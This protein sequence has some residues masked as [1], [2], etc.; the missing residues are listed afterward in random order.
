MSRNNANSREGDTNRDHDQRDVA[1][2]AASSSLTRGAS[3]NRPWAVDQIAETDGHQSFDPSRYV[4]RNV[5]GRTQ[6]V[7]GVTFVEDTDDLVQFTPQVQDQ[8]RRNSSIL[9]QHK[10]T[11]ASSYLLARR[12]VQSSETRP[13]GASS[14]ISSSGIPLASTASRPSHVTSSKALPKPPDSAASGDGGESSYQRYLAQRRRQLSAPEASDP[15]LRRQQPSLSSASTSNWNQNNS[16]SSFDHANNSLELL[17]SLSD[18]NLEGQNSR[19]LGFTAPSSSQQLTSKSQSVPQ[20]QKVYAGH[21]SDSSAMMHYSEDNLRKRLAEM[22]QPR[23]ESS[24][25]GKNIPKHVPSNVGHRRNSSNSAKMAMEVGGSNDKSDAA[26]DMRSRR[27]ARELEQRSGRNLMDDVGYGSRNNNSSNFGSSNDRPSPDNVVGPNIGSRLT[28]ISSSSQTNIDVEKYL[29][30]REKKDATSNNSL[31][32]SLT[33]NQLFRESHNEDV[34][35][36][37]QSTNVKYRARTE[38]ENNNRN[39]LKGES[40]PLPASSKFK[41]SSSMSTDFSSTDLDDDLD[42]APRA[43]RSRIAK[44]RS[45][46]SDDLTIL[47]EQ[48]QSVSSK[49]A[50]SIS[51]ASR[52]TG[53]MLGKNNLALQ[54][55]LQQTV[56]PESRPSPT[57]NQYLASRNVRIASE[58]HTPQVGTSF[59]GNAIYGQEDKALLVSD[60]SGESDEEESVIDL[61]D[62]SSVGSD[63]SNDA[64]A[65]QTDWSV[66]ICIVSAVDFP[67]NVVPN[68]P[69]SPLLKVGLVPFPR[70]DSGEA[71]CRKISS[72]VER[73]GLSSINKSRLRCS[74]TKILSKRDNG[75]VEYHEEMRWDRVKNPQK[76]ALVLELCSRSVMTPANIK[77]SPPPQFRQNIA[78]TL[79]STGRGSGSPVPGASSRRQQTSQNADT[80]SS[81][82]GSLFRRPN[83]RKA[84]SAEMEEANAAAAVAKLLV[85]GGADRLGSKGNASTTSQQSNEID[86]KLRPRKK[87]SFQKSKMTNDLRLGSTVVPLTCLAL[88][89]AMTDQGESARIEQWFELKQSHTTSDAS[90]PTSPSRASSLATGR[91]PSV[92]LEITFTSSERLN[93]SEDE[94]DDDEDASPTKELSASF[95][96]RASQKIRK[97]LKQETSATI[98]VPAKELVEPSLEPGIIDYAFIVGARD[99]G[100]QKDDDGAKGWVNSTPEFCILEQFPPN[101]EFHAK[102]GRKAIL[103]NKVEWFCFPDGCRLWRGLTPPNYDEL[104]LKRFSA[105]SPSQIATSFASFDACLGCTTCFSWFVMATNS[106]DYGS[107]MVKTYGAIIRFYVPAPTGIDPKQDDYAQTLMMSHSGHKPD[108]T[109][110]I[111]NV[112]IGVGDEK[113]RLWVNYYYCTEF[114]YCF[115]TQNFVFPLFRY[116]LESALHQ[117]YQSLVPWR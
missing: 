61:T 108:A 20:E 111:S 104:R 55:R 72:T 35:R 110:T 100:D 3:H 89:K 76:T 91:N 70:E 31:L 56:S 14:A 94:M 78:L 52:Q 2:M 21:Q 65:T 59:T 85:Q 60:S 41:P 49:I 98:E 5:T 117:I 18:L 73:S 80:P 17:G 66:R 71:S 27:L 67:G 43:F 37:L 102:N 1:K 16:R 82:L 114:N 53:E 23:S 86:V 54:G 101:D 90:S 63:A 57:V 77:E 116:L 75:S 30:M 22:T 36:Y 15:G 113:K 106:E 7:D 79:Q 64:D 13:S 45:K 81:G 74:S 25:V 109:K 4:N 12:A 107:E 87:K 58:S 29:Q 51:N 62:V 28:H 33:D 105:S 112:G 69:F 92:L 84:D 115:K 93:D 68:L 26:R 88:N 19:R 97:Q 47:T 10:E 48:P 32:M 40:Q 34:E 95:S 99:I 96:K 39:S 50:S 9:P 6:A 44:S 8:Q 46:S 11:D 103:P 38:A 42:G 24:D 83:L